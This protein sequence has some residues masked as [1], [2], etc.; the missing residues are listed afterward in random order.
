MPAMDVL[1]PDGSPAA[2]DV[3][4]DVNETALPPEYGPLADLDGD[5]VNMTR[6]VSGTYV[7]LPARLTL[8]Y[9]MSYGLERKVLFLVLAN[10]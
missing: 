10:D 6:D 2:V 7:L 1:L 9:A 8:D 4:F 5:G 3:S